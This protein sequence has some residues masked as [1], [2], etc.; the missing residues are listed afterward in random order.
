[1]SK[2]EAVIDYIERRLIQLKAAESV[3]NAAESIGNANSRKEID[4][5][6]ERKRI[7]I[8]KLTLN[9]KWQKNTE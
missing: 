7:N 8:K 3:G 1:M 5:L 4:H 2:A 6:E 9:N